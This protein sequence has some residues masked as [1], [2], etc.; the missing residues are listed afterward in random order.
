MFYHLLAEAVEYLHVALLCPLLV[1]LASVVVQELI[2]YGQLSQQGTST[3]DNINYDNLRYEGNIPYIDGSATDILP[4]FKTID[5]DGTSLYFDL[6]GRML[7]YKP[8]KGV[9]IE[10][11]KKYVNN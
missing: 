9:Y 11:G 6:Q 1:L 5:T 10:D 8:L 7:R 4:T 2:A 3:G